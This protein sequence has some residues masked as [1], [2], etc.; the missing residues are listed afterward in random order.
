MEN[1]L[2]F[3]ITLPTIVTKCRSIMYN[4]PND[5]ERFFATHPFIL[6]SIILFALY[7]FPIVGIYI[8]A[9]SS[10][11]SIFYPKLLRVLNVIL[12]FSISLISASNLYFSE[13]SWLAFVP[14]IVYPFLIWFFI[15]FLFTAYVN[16]RYSPDLGVVSYLGFL[17]L[18][19]L[20]LFEGSL[21]SDTPLYMTHFRLN[22]I[23]V[24]VVFALTALGISE[25]L[26][27]IMGELADTMKD[28]LDIS[29][30]DAKWISGTFED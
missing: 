8:D 27:P 26:R 21:D 1:F 22:D 3:V 20:A 6:I 11:K 7:F 25:I 24:S 28:E 15:N 19:L 5:I 4:P 16:F 29:D 9:I 10:K 23:I 18:Q 17:F 30:E 12:F 13:A 14:S 2:R